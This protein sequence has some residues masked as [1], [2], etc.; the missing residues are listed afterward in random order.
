MFGVIRRAPDAISLNH[1]RAVVDAA[2][3]Q[4]NSD[5]A[6]EY[7]SDNDKRNELRVT[8]DLTFAVDPDNPSVGLATLPD[9]L[10]KKYLNDCSLRVGVATLVPL[11]KYAYRPVYDDFLNGGDSRLGRWSTNS[12]IIGATKPATVGVGPTAL[13][14]AAKFICICSPDIP[15]LETDEYAAPDDFVP[16]FIDSFID[17]ILAGKTMTQS[18]S[19]AA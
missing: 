16:D 2:F 1:L 8:K 14:G 10:L 4:V 5:V 6:E 15:V 12:N 9:G 7:A 19:T 17:W 18:A 3:P 13:T 11:Q